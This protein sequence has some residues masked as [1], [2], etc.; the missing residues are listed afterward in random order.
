MPIPPPMNP[1][2]A[3]QPRPPRPAEGPYVPVPK[4]EGQL[5]LQVAQVEEVLKVPLI[6]P[7]VIPSVDP[8]KSYLALPGAELREAAKVR[9]DAIVSIV[10][11]LRRGEEVPQHIVEKFA[12]Q[13]R[14]LNNLELSVQRYLTG[15]DGR[16]RAAQVEV[17]SDIAQALGSGELKGYLKLPTGFGKTRIFAALTEA[18]DVKTLVLV[19]K[20]LLCEQTVEQYRKLS[21]ELEVRECHGGKN[22][23]DGKIVISTYQYFLEASKDGRIDPKAFDLVILDEGHKALGEGTQE[24]LA[25][26]P[27]TVPTIAFTA[28]PAYSE[29]KSLEALMGECWHEVSL[30]EGI[31]LGALAPVSVVLAK[32]TID[33]SSVEVSGVHYNEAEF[34]KAVKKAGLSQS[35]L[36]LYQKGFSGCSAIG[37]CCSVAHAQEAA[38][39]FRQAGISAVALSG[40]TKPAERDKAIADF[41]EGKIQALFSADLLI[42]GFDAAN[43]SVCLN[44]APTA[45]IVSA[46][47]RGGRVLRLDPKD[48]LKCAVVVDFVFS[49]DR[50]ALPQVFFSSILGAID[51]PPADEASSAFREAIE[52]KRKELAALQ[53][54][55][56]TLVVEEKEIM[57]VAHEVQPEQ[58][59][60]EA[61]AG[62][63]TL[64]ALAKEVGKPPN[65]ATSAIKGLAD[66]LEGMSGR[67]ISP[68]TGRPT[69]M[70]DPAVVPLIQTYRRDTLKEA[71]WVR[72]SDVSA[73]LARSSET[74]REQLDRLIERRPELRVVGSKTQKGKGF[75]FYHPSV[76]DILR[77]DT[78]ADHRR[79]PRLAIQDLAG[80]LMLPRIV[81]EDIVRKMQA[82][83]PDDVREFN[84][85]PHFIEKVKSHALDTYIGSYA[86]KNGRVT[87]A[88]LAEYLEIDPQALIDAR[89]GLVQAGTPPWTLEKEIPADKVSDMCRLILVHLEKPETWEPS[90]RLS[91]ARDRLVRQ[92]VSHLFPQEWAQNFKV[93][94]GRGRAHYFHPRLVKLLE[95]VEQLK[96]EE[97]QRSP[98]P[99]KSASRST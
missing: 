67:F 86:D 91:N 99:K 68:E 53:I 64:A 32:T 25:R 58:K 41:K 84:C 16:L 88:S 9:Y 14:L 31:R 1:D 65:M 97:K 76:V 26:I 60:A 21:P 4:A 73:T 15:Q 78:S 66:R 87:I 27:D 62:W 72:A 2:T 55:G 37:F 20:S 39:T 29:K 69:T 12:H 95:T 19:P 24:A 48:E 51:C 18:A 8:V 44:M 30:S 33:L 57:R 34:T 98:S 90:V 6:P 93:P 85:K 89:Q 94:G 74:V 54:D 96:A 52:E 23:G 22:E 17:M 61:P 7:S 11:Y 75:D 47:Q 40:E 38:E 56:L 42:E 13:I 59:Y 70:F 10:P 28:T 63:L 36:Q 50:R 35:A 43:A 49:D 71:G 80:Q 46:E 3:K 5:R 45:S 83:Y 92:S 77:E 82:D 81:V 79:W